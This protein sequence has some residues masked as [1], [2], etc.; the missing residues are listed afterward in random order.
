TATGDNGTVLD[1][2]PTKGIHLWGAQ[3][4]MAPDPGPY[5]PTTT[6]AVSAGASTLTVALDEGDYEVR[7]TTA[8]GE[9]VGGLLEEDGEYPI[10]TFGSPIRSVVLMP[11]NEPVTEPV[12]IVAHGNSLTAGYGLGSP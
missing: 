11:A 3:I 12:Q 2:D 4:V 8:L 1:G 5:I 10:Q 6:A 7:Y 9:Y